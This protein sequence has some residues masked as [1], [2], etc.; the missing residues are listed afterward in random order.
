M[1]GLDARPSFFAHLSHLGPSGGDFQASR[2]NCTC[3]EKIVD[4]KFSF[5]CSLTSAVGS[6]E[7]GTVAADCNVSSHLGGNQMNHASE[8]IREAVTAP[9]Y[10]Y[11]SPPHRTCFLD[12]NSTIYYALCCV[13]SCDDFIF[14][15]C[16]C[17]HQITFLAAQV[18]HESQ[19]SCLI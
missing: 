16:T 18:A 4:N 17:L 3:T 5:L 13:Y 14:A 11:Y 7:G 15:D 1:G 2:R 9:L 6:C 19:M 10:Y 8:S 12:E